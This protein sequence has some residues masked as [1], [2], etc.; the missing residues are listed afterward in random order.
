MRR[1]APPFTRA[2]SR[3]VRSLGRAVDLRTGVGFFAARVAAGRRVV[4][5]DVI[6]EKGGT[7]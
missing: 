4:A 7:A 5:M 2:A 3:A 6:L 1:R